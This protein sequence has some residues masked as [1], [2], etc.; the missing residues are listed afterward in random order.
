MDASDKQPADEEKR[1]IVTKNGPYRVKGNIPLV[2]KTQIVSEYGEPLS[3]KKEGEI[4][5]GEGDYFLCRCG[6]S[7]N[8]PFCDGT[9]RKVGFDGTERAPTS[10]TADRRRALRGGV[11]LVVEKDGSLCMAAGFC[12]MRKAAL[13]QY[14]MASSDTEARSLAIAM[15]ERCPSGSLTYRI[16]ADEP[17][18]EPDLPQEI[19]D[20]TEIT[21]DGPIAGPLWVSGG[22]SVERSDGQPFETRNRVTLCNCGNSRLKPLCDGTH[23]HEA[24]RLGRLRNNE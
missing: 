8:K 14:V 15:V 19:V 4:E 16:E 20:T 3:W 18:I 2:R 21:S 11:H 5:T 24:R 23:R 17:D 7:G 22:I 1:I 9:H 10:L 6:Q 12:G 13:A